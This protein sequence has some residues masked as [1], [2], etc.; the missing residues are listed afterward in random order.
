MK[1]LLFSIAALLFT[2]SSIAQL[3][4]KPNGSDESYVYVQDQ[5]LYVTGDIDLTENPAGPEEASIYF[6]DGGQ[7]IQGNDVAV[8]DIF[9]FI[10]TTQTLMPGT[11]LTGVLLLVTKPLPERIIRILERCAFLI[12]K[13]QKMLVAIVT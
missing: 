9:Q 1:N 6:R 11:M 7:L 3:Y 8:R 10:K 4:V 12:P 2:V 5:I 13:E